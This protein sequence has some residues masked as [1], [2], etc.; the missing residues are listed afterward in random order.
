MSDTVQAALLLAVILLIFLI[1]ILQEKFKKRAEKKEGNDEEPIQYSSPAVESDTAACATNV[2]PDY[3]SI[4]LGSFRFYLPDSLLQIRL[5]NDSKPLQEYFR[6]LLAYTDQ[7]WSSHDYGDARGLL[8]TFGVR[9]LF[10]EYQAWLDA[11]HEKSSEGTQPQDLYTSIDAETTC[12]S[13]FW[14]DAV[15]GD[16]DEET[17]RAFEK[18]LAAVP[19]VAVKLGPVA[20]A[21][22]IHFT[23]CTVTKFPK[24]PSAWQRAAENSHQSLMIPDEL[25]AEIWPPIRKN[26]VSI[27]HKKRRTAAVIGENGVHARIF[28]HTITAREGMI[29]CRSFVTVGLIDLGQKEIVLTLRRLPDEPPDPCPDEPLRLLSSIYQL[30]SK[31]KIVNIGDFTQLGERTFY[32]RH[33][34][35]IRTVPLSGVVLP[36]DGLHA[37]LI[38]AQELDALKRFGTTRIMALLGEESRF[39]PCPPW[40]DRLRSGLYFSDMTERSILSRVQHIKAPGVSVLYSEKRLTIKLSRSL[41]PRFAEIIQ[42]R[43]SSGMLTM[44]TEL[45]SHADSCFY[46]RPGQ[47]EPSAISPPGST[48]ENTCCCFIILCKAP[49]QER[50]EARVIE[51]G[52]SV[53]LTEESWETVNKAFIDSLDT[54]LPINDKLSLYLQWVGSPEESLQTSEEDQSDTA[55]SLN[56]EAWSCYQ[57]GKYAEAEELYQRALAVYEK[58]SGEE[59]VRILEPLGNL[60]AFYSQQERREEAEELYLRAVSISEKTRGK[61]HPDIAWVLNNL[62]NLYAKQ[63]KF[64]EADSLYRRSAAILEKQLDTD[65]AY[66]S[67][68]LVNWAELHRTRGHYQQ[69]E[70]LYQRVLAVGEKSLPPDHPYITQS[71]SN[72]GWIYCQQKKYAEAA[73]LYQRLL[74]IKMK[75]LD[76]E[77]PDILQYMNWLADF[78]SDQ[79]EYVKAEDLLRQLLKTAEDKHGK[80]SNEVVDILIRS[81]V[82]CHQ[83]SKYTEAEPLYLRILKLQEKLLHNDHPNVALTLNNLAN[84]YA[85]QGNY[86]AAEPFYLRGIALLE[87]AFPEGHPQLEG[88]RKNYERMK[89]DQAGQE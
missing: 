67:N 11:L 44:L 36:D 45:D 52:V 87:T 5:G 75:S 53:L 6:K 42:H 65:P 18:E 23:G 26:G 9:P 68:N 10:D 49:D 21:V 46:W 59:D 35:Y 88:I 80:E 33:L 29:P 7:Y 12:E 85:Q 43:F 13:R 3:S 79:K 89:R 22:N 57:Q 24:M 16:I 84:L 40:S 47:S 20:F 73:P 25:F 31:G 19:P 64:E 81:A 83:Q 69:A 76:R 32:G 14:C 28:Y 63:E 77:H 8:I 61:E 50:N 34:A 15:E 78:Y 60:A 56:D 51:D 37:I 41:Q 30:A 58:T 71:L 48:G 38:T 82:L 70:A 39:Y 4:T 74:D 62:A 2:Q 66:L 55:Q 17:L 72:L 1:P 86:S 54:H 27:K